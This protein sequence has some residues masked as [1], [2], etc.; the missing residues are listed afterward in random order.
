[1]R[2]QPGFEILTGIFQN[3]DFVPFLRSSLSVVLGETYD[4]LQKKC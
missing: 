2:S 4:L 1:M 3:H